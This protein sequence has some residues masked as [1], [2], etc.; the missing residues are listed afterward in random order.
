MDGVAC[1][2]MV[3]EGEGHAF[4]IWEKVGGKV[5]VRTLRP[6][7]KWVARVVRDGLL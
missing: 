5:D 2:T 1:E 4:D 7:V 6:A 3:V